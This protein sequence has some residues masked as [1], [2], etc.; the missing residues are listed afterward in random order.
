MAGAADGVA[1][2]AQG[3]GRRYGE[4]EAAIDALVDVDVEFP[5]GQFAAVMG[6]SGSGKS[7]L[8]HCLAGLDIPT[9]GEVTIAGTR[10]GGL[11]D[12]DLTV[13]RRT[14]IG[15]IFQSFN[16]LPMLTARENVE[17]PLR[18][19]G[20]LDAAK[21]DRVLQDVGLADRASHRPAELSGGQQQRVAIA[22]ALVGEPTVIFADE[23]TG[24]LD[25]A[26][27]HEILELLRRAVDE[28]GRTVVMVTHDPRAATIADRVIMLSDGRVVMDRSGMDADQIY[29]AVRT[30]DPL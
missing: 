16:L 5:L 3:L 4:G 28:D 14:D 30:L 11:S 20:T 13:L 10:L 17:L 18:I 25:S 9:A 2:R 1:V 23:P 7:T 19:A 6:P 22:R 12:R 29:D 27:G 15:F 26:S 24:N 8:L 21:V